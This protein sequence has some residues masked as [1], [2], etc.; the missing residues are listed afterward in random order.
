MV[1]GMLSM[2]TVENNYV[3]EGS[4]RQEINVYIL[5]AKKTRK[6]LTCI[7]GLVKATGY[8]IVVDASAVNANWRASV[9]QNE[10]RALHIILEYLL[11]LRSKVT[12]T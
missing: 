6:D 8:V 5:Q 9:R 4:L 3:E 7:S 2:C 10:E 1:N 11:V 12:C